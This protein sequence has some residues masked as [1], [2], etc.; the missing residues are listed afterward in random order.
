MIKAGKNGMKNVREPLMN[1]II[2]KKTHTQR[3]KIVKQWNMLQKPQKVMI[4]MINVCM[5]LL[6]LNI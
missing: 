1:L 4:M 2:L 3:N 5:L 6:C